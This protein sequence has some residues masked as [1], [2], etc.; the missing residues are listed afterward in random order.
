VVG[1]NNRVVLPLSAVF[2]A[3]FV[4][5]CDLCARVVFSPYEI[6]VGILMAFLGGPFFVYLIVKNRRYG[7][8]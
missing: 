6:P 4:V 1:H 7:D 2:G 3:G 8:G 5:F